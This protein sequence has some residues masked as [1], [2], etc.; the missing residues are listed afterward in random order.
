[1]SDPQRIKTLSSQYKARE[2]VDDMMLSQLAGDVAALL[3]QR[4][5]RLVL[6]ESC[7]AGLISATLAVVPGISAHFCGSS[8]VYRER[9]KKQWLGVDSEMLRRWTAVSQ[10]ATAAVT[11]GVLQQTDEA[12]L[13]LGITGHL[14]PD[15]PPDL[16]G[17]IF[18]AIW[19]R[20]TGQL[21]DVTATQ[22]KLLMDQRVDRQQES[23]QRA[24]S[25][26]KMWIK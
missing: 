21:T 16:D 17:Q 12:T 23:V 24:L 9:T 25:L 20:G 7:T 13:A 3:E 11:Q 22:E 18:I 2:T 10:Q 26:L 8:V 15:A 5:Q 4:D 14:G 1:M 6:A 19:S